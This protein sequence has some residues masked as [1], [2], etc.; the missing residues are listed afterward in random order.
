M[1]VSDVPM[2]RAKT[3]SEVKNTGVELS[4]RQIVSPIYHGKLRSQPKT[5]FSMIPS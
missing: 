5:V 3:G 4:Y 2:G 1:A